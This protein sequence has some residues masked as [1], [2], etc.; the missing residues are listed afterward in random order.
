MI[1]LAPAATGF[2]LAVDMDIPFSTFLDRWRRDQHFIFSVSRHIE[3]ADPEV[4]DQNRIFSYLWPDG[5]ESPN[6]ALEPQYRQRLKALPPIALELVCSLPESHVYAWEEHLPIWKEVLARLKWDPKQNV[7][8]LAGAKLLANRISTGWLSPKRLCR[9][10]WLEMR[11]DGWKDIPDIEQRL[12]RLTTSFQGVSTPYEKLAAL[13]GF[14]TGRIPT[15]WTMVENALLQE[16]FSWP[17]LV[18]DNQAIAYALPSIVDVEL[19]IDEGDDT[20]LAQIISG[21]HILADDWQQHLEKARDAAI[22]LWETKRGANAEHLQNLVRKARVTIDLRVASDI[23]HA[24][25]SHGK[26]E[27]TDGSL[28]AYI[29]TEILSRILGQTA[30]GRVAATGTLNE[31]IPNGQGAYESDGG[32]YTIDYVGGILSKVRCANRAFYFDKMIV[33]VNSVSEIE[34]DQDNDESFDLE[35]IEAHDPD[36]RLGRHVKNNGMF[37]A[38]AKFSLG[39]SWRNHRYV[40]CPDIEVAFKSEKP[41]GQRNYIPSRFDVSRDILRNEHPWYNSVVDFGSQYSGAQIACALYWKLCVAMWDENWPDIPDD[42]RRGSFAFVRTTC[43]EQNERFWATV[44]DACG[45]EAEGFRQFVLSKSAT[46]A[47]QHLAGLLNN[48]APS[49]RRR[50]RAP[51]VL[52]IIGANRLIRADE[53]ALKLSAERSQFRLAT[54]LEELKKPGLLDRCPNRVLQTKLLNCRIIAVDEAEVERFVLPTHELRAGLQR[55]AVRLSTFRRGFSLS[56]AQTI[57]GLNRDLTRKTLDELTQYGDDG[58]PVI[59]YSEG[60]DEYWMNYEPKFIDESTEYSN[61]LAA[62]NALVGLLDRTDRPEHEDFA[63]SLTP[64]HLH[65]AQWHVEKAFHLSQRKLAKRNVAQ[66][67]RERLS[68]IG[69]PFTW[70]QLVWNVKISNEA[71]EEIWAEVRQA[72]RETG[73]GNL[74]ITHM[75]HIAEY[76]DKL[77][78]K[79]PSQK[80]YFESVYR[81]V[82]TFALKRSSKLPAREANAARFKILAFRAWMAMKSSPDCNGASAA[83]VDSRGAWNCYPVHG[84]EI[85]YSE[86]FEQYGDAIDDHWEALPR[87]GKG[88]LNHKV[89]G[90]TGLGLSPMVKWLGCLVLTREQATASEWREITAALTD[91]HK[92]S[93]KEWAAVGK[94]PETGL[95]RRTVAKRRLDA[96]MRLILSKGLLDA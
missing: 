76:A 60:T 71:R 25:F 22:K 4:A 35:L 42:K 90:A 75:L 92:S 91:E 67:H 27:L 88:F 62:A 70:S 5:P 8:R 86:W 87:Y 24:E 30:C 13:A 10:A 18:P 65:E 53:E 9:I 84:G 46:E 11:A 72:V 21:E 38:Y 80:H 85:L 47:A 69:E 29:A 63:V 54:L 48:L 52:V 51:D 39:Q 93:L 26:L 94:L 56:V 40:R 68:R 7:S 82:I 58:L 43:N 34:K 95:H 81:K 6:C 1:R 66:S 31:F 83:E 49:D 14:R 61:Q 2:D 57:L 3:N 41:A 12:S 55:P 78:K 28:G 77:S 19:G 37:G 16:L 74:K 32:D 17:L 89:A 20:S 96:G 15:G 44:W 79:V 45:G 73:I 36:N 33:P 64:E 23:F 59:Q 50:V